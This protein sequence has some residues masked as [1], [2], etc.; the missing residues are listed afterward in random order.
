MKVPGG[1]RTGINIK[2]NDIFI[3]LESTFKA[4]QHKCVNSGEN[5][6]SNKYSMEK[7]KGTEKQRS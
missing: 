7:I 3:L 1:K 2:K 5:D 4:L 6:H